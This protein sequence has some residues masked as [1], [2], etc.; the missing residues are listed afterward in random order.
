MAAVAPKELTCRDFRNM[1]FFH[2]SDQSIEQLQEF[3]DNHPDINI[4]ARCPN[5]F[6]YRPLEFLL[7]PNTIKRRERIEILLKKGADPNLPCYGGGTLLYQLCMMDPD[8]KIVYLLVEYGA[9][10]NAITHS[11]YAQDS[12]PLHAAGYSEITDKDFILALL[13]CGA[14]INAIDSRGCSPIYYFIR[15]NAPLP[16]IDLMIQR[17][18][19]GI[20]PHDCPEEMVIYLIYHGFDYTNMQ[21]NLLRKYKDVIIQYNRE[22]VKLITEN[23]PLP[24]A[25]ASTIIRWLDPNS[26]FLM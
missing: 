22:R 6:Y 25:L 2:E 17:G 3:I 1:G 19:T 20:I 8:P 14:N 11:S 15:N 12:T 18:A 21:I 13:D 5:Y 4:N 10:I 24:I 7:L 16:I 9:N 23:T 26:E